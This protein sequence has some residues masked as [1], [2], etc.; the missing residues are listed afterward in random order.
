MY[1][2]LVVSR[3]LNRLSGKYPYAQFRCADRKCAKKFSVT[4]GTVMDCSKIKLR[5]WFAA[6]YLISAHK[7]GISSHQLDRYLGV[8]QKT[9]KAAL[10]NDLRPGPIE[11][12]FIKST[13]Q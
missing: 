7:K 6:M 8:C 3:Q 4:V 5:Y 11:H 12:R 9:G 1:K 10:K 13:R 2:T